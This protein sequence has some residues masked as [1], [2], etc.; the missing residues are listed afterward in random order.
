MMEVQC[1]NAEALASM[2]TPE[3]RTVVIYDVCQRHEPWPINV[4]NAVREDEDE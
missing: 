2:S 3:A 4:F 1:L